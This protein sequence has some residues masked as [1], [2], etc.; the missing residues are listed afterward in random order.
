MLGKPCIRGTRI[1][2]EHV[3]RNL[4]AGRTV[5]EL[6]DAYPHLNAEDVRASM[7]YAAND[8]R[9]RAMRRWRRRVAA[10]PPGEKPR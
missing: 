10:N 2:V 5:E 3:L 7:T 6:L 8:L 4:G 9:E 1:T